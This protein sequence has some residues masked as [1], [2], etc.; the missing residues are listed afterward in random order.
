MRSRPPHRP[1]SALPKPRPPM[2]LD[3]TR[4]PAQT[5]LPNARLARRNPW[6]SKI[7]AAAPDSRNRMQSQ[8][9]S[10]GLLRARIVLARLGPT[11]LPTRPL[12]RTGASLPVL[13]LGTAPSG[14]RPEREAVAFYHRC[15]DAGVTHLDTGPAVG[16]FGR[17]QAALGHVLSERRGEAFVATRV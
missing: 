3:R 7:R 13:G 2:K 1:A 14:H 10:R 12:G 8:V 15:L 17:A 5:L 9:L 16:G 4:L 11:M 6:A